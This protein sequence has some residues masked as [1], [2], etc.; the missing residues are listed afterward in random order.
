[1]LQPA[2]SAPQRVASLASASYQHAVSAP[3]PGPAPGPSAEA[4]LTQ[5]AGP[6]DLAA[7]S[8][9]SSG[10]FGSDFFVTQVRRENFR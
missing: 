5:P 9:D 2:P 8:S 1:M 3:A 7:A 4:A 10:L 6:S